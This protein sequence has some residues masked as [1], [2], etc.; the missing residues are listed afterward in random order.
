M[1]YQFLFL[2][3]VSA[4]FLRFLDNSQTINF[5]PFLIVLGVFTTA[6][7]HTLFVKSFKN[8][9]VSTA[10]IISTSQPVYGILFGLIFLNEIPNLNII[11]GGCII[12][13]TVVIESLSIRAKKG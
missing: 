13:S 1:F 2:I 5:I 12:I 6:I 11:I 4:P 10:S 9:P 7:G 3:I 8:F